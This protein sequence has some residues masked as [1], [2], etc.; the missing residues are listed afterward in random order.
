MKIFFNERRWGL[1]QSSD[2]ER[3]LKLQI[4]LDSD[5]DMKDTTRGS[6]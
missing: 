1:G 2:L 6:A 3:D 4:E 5:D